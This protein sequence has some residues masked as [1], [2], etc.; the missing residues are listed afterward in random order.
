[1]TIQ[2]PTVIKD[3]PGY[4]KLVVKTVDT[5]RPRVQIQGHHYVFNS[6]VTV[7]RRMSDDELISRLSN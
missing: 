6:E 7:G 1:M 2:I 5:S 3:G 4:W